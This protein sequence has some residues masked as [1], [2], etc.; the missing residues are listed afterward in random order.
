MTSPYWCSGN[1]CVLR[2]D[3]PSLIHIWVA[4]SMPDGI[5]RIHANTRRGKLEGSCHPSRIGDVPYLNGRGGASPFRGKSPSSCFERSYSRSWTQ[6]QIGAARAC[7]VSVKGGAANESGL[8]FLVRSDVGA[9]RFRRCGPGT[10]SGTALWRSRR[11][12]SSQRHSRKKVTSSW[13]VVRSLNAALTRLFMTP[14][15]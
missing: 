12:A 4:T 6:G 1:L 10:G 3:W 9:T 13:N 11:G 5:D 14:Q 2:P 15:R 7:P 8:C